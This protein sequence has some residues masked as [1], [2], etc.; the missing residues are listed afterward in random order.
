MG[1]HKFPKVMSR[2]VGIP[3]YYS[4]STTIDVPKGCIVVYVGEGTNKRFV[5]PLT[6]LKHHSFQSLLKLSEEEFG[7][8]HPMG[9]LTLPCKEE[10][11]IKITHDIAKFVDRR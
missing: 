7:Y 8:V 3:R 9:G 10:T 11:F 1:I 5:V 2:K 6:Y 4:T